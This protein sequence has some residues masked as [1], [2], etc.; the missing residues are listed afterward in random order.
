MECTYVVITWWQNTCIWCLGIIW[1]YWWLWKQLPGRVTSFT[2][3]MCIL[4]RKTVVMKLTV[5]T[6]NI[7]KNTFPSFKP[8]LHAEWFS[9]FLYTCPIHILCKSNVISSFKAHYILSCNVADNRMALALTL[10]PPHT[11]QINISSSMIPIESELIW[12]E[13]K[14]NKQ[15]MYVSIWKT[16]VVQILALLFLHPQASYQKSGINSLWSIYTHLSP[17]QSSCLL[18]ELLHMECL[19]TCRTRKSK[20]RNDFSGM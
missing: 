2:W 3:K 11:R 9:F 15:V 20:P 13:G 17:Q 8:Q 14:N 12:Y 1:V 19:S 18:L 4:L 16:Y 7:C 6:P 10:R 5:W